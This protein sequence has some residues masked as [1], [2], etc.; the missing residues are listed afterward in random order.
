[1]RIG[2]LMI[3]PLFL[4]V[5][6]A[7]I[8]CSVDWDNPDS[9]SVD[10]MIAGPDQ[11]V[12][13]PPS[14]PVETPQASRAAQIGQPGKD[15]LSV[16]LGSTPSSGASTPQKARSQELNQT[17]M[18]QPIV[19]TN[20]GVSVQDNTLSNV[21]TNMIGK[22][23]ISGVN[24]TTTDQWVEIANGGASNVSFTGWMLMNKENLSYS[25]PTG[26]VLEPGALVKVHSMAGNNNSTDLYNS[27]VLWSK[28]GDT[29]VLMD[30]TGRTVSKYSY[31]A[32]SSE[33]SKATTDA[34]KSNVTTPEVM[35]YKATN[36]KT[37]TSNVTTKTSKDITKITIVK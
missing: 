13:I 8:A 33:T 27:S 14:V 20:S 7:I 19:T 28:N 21:G 23:S 22:V 12:L 5:L 2:I 25:F 30:A 1:M 26:I 3:L 6:F 15:I 16:P 17:A 18:T 10:Q 35:A 36:T 32:V 9:Q 37:T 31:P 4:L 34:T 24:Y 29:V 11:G